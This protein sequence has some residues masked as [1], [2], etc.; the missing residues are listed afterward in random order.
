MNKNLS[1]ITKNIGRKIK[2]HSPEIL[3]GIGIAGMISASS[4]EYKALG[5]ALIALTAVITT[6][7]VPIPVRM[8]A[9][10]FLMK[11]PVLLNNLFILFTSSHQKK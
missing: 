11:H 4:I 7:A 6:P 8:V 2:K 9:T 3:T 1:V 5:V 10:F